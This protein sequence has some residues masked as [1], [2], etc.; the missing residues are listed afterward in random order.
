M[1][2]A[3]VK[4]LVPK[5][6]TIRLADLKNET[7]D[8]NENEYLTS[9]YDDREIETMYGERYP[10]IPALGTTLVLKEPEKAVSPDDIRAFEH[11]SYLAERVFQEAVELRALFRYKKPNMVAMNKPRAMSCIELATENLGE[12]KKYV[13]AQGV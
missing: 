5:N 9:N 7:L 1:T 13:K 12:L 2:V 10:W 8:I 4:A 6:A 3:D 11:A